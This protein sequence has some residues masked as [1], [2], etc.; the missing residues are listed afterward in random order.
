M[1]V[2]FRTTVPLHGAFLLQ[3]AQAK[4][5]L[6]A[7]DLVRELEDLQRRC[8]AKELRVVARSDVLEVTPVT[9]PELA[10]K[11]IRSLS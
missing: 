6:R 11:R 8:D 10:A 5:F 3:G 7:E 9:S 4:T 1:I 2:K